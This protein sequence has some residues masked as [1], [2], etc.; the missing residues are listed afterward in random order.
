MTS[1]LRL[2][3]YKSK[4]LGK[5]FFFIK[6]KVTNNDFFKSVQE[7][8]KNGFSIIKDFLKIDECQT[9][10]KD[11]NKALEKKKKNIISDKLNSDQRLFGFQRLNCIVN[12][13][14]TNEDIRNVG[15]NYANSFLE[16][17]YVLA[18]R[19]QFIDGNEGSGGGWHRDNYNK[20]FKAMIYL[21]DVNKDNGPLEI[22]AESHKI[23]NMIIHKKYIS[24]Y[25]P[26]TRYSQHDIQK[27]IFKEQKLN[28]LIGAA[29]TLI[30]FDG[31]LIHRGS[32]LKSGIRYAITSYYYPK[33]E[34]RYHL[35]IKQV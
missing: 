28:T 1:S 14:Y 19:V 4:N 10:I 6:K 13:F 24:N 29:G 18:N 30:L 16:N 9:I 7:L 20:Q 27:I 21:S 8:N 32:P 5:K 35:D 2:I 26:N 22:I 3:K 25:F 11:I 31:S 15:S 34:I 33:N 12:K 17:A 23:Y